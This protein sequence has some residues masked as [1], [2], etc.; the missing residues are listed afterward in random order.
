MRLDDQRIATFLL[1]LL[2]QYIQYL[3][4]RSPNTTLAAQVYAKADDVCACGVRSAT[5]LPL[6]ACAKFHC[7]WK[8]FRNCVLL[9]EWH[10]AQHHLRL[11]DASGIYLIAEELSGAT[12]FIPHHNSACCSAGLGGGTPAQPRLTTKE[13]AAP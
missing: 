3:F 2:M 1:S 7:I 11:L 6:S 10:V 8:I 12:I 5:R 4:G 13:L 9:L